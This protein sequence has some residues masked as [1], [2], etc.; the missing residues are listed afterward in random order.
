M[1]FEIGN[2]VQIP[3]C[4]THGHQ[5]RNAC[6]ARVV[7]APSK[8]KKFLTGLYQVS[9]EIANNEGVFVNRSQPFEGWEL[10]KI[11]N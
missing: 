6:I 3:A 4:Y 1:Y 11:S 8:R 9:Y 5:V 2:K 7:I 10:V